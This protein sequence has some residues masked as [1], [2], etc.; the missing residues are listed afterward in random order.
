MLILPKLT[1]PLAD[2]PKIVFVQIR[3][4]Y[5]P[6]A[7][8]RTAVDRCNCCEANEAKLPD[9]VLKPFQLIGSS[10]G[11]PTFSHCSKLLFPICV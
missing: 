2:A 4:Q 3:A 8:G 10:V 11:F 7:P 1:V 6:E 5:C 9:A